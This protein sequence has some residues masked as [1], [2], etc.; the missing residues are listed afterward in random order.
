MNHPQHLISAIQELEVSALCFGL[1][2]N[3]AE[4]YRNSCYTTN[5]KV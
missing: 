5:I 4:L 1:P 2:W 3:L